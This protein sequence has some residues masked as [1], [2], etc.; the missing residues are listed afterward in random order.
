MQ[1][2]PRNAA[3]WLAEGDEHYAAGRWLEA[4][5]A[6]EAALLHDPAQA[7]AWYRLGNVREEQARDGDAVVCFERAIALEPDHA[8]AWNNLGG[9]RQRMGRDEE[10]A[11][12][13]REAMR[14]DPE[15]PQPY[16][17]L[18]RLAAGRGDRV[19][20]AECFRNGLAR[21]PDD[22]MLQHLLA[23]VEGR[24]TERAPEA[25]VTALFDGF[26]Q[27]FER[28]LVKELQ[29]RVPT[30][31]AAMIAPRLAKLRDAPVRARVIDL[32]CGTGLVGA[33]LAGTGAEV[34]GVDLASR[35]LEVAAARGDYAGLEQGELLE[36]LARAAPGSAQ[37]VVAA[38]V[39]IYVGDLE[40]VFAAVTRVLAPA[41]LFALSVEGL[42]KGDYQLRPSGRYAQSPAYLRALARRTGLE[43][44]RIEATRVRREGSGYA[45]GWL[46]LFA[47]P[48]RLTTA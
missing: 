10:A 12:A 21:H 37:A 45:E 33:A 38:D 25:Y 4:G 47:K 14:A 9:A 28:H 26:A 19:L 17:N 41:G 42:E 3:D 7:R 2:S 24:D 1:G 11:A 29:Y 40:Q 48:D 16:L 13:Y 22:P 36:M 44:L 39:F 15:L 5:I 30:E 8:R 18:G 43:E 35:M 32:G 27:N 23:A 34:I 46:A 6:L 20:A 31:L